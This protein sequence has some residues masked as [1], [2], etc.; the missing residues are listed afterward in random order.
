MSQTHKA[1]FQTLKDYYDEGNVPNLVLFGDY[2]SGKKKLLSDFVNYIYSK[3]KRKEEYI[4]RVNCLNANGI[5]FVRDDIKFFAQ[6]VFFNQDKNQFKSIIL[7]NAELL[8]IDAQSA[9]RRCIELFSKSTRFFLVV[10]NKA[11][12]LKP[13]LSRFSSFFVPR[14]GDTIRNKLEESK[15]YHKEFN[16]QDITKLMEQVKDDKQTQTLK[17]VK[18]RLEDAYYKGINGQNMVDYISNEIEDNLGKYELLN[19]LN[20]MSRFYRNER[21][22]MF[23]VYNLYNEFVRD[24]VK[25]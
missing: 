19:K 12:L 8:T 23:H 20:N 17:N 24:R 15:M 16:K 25:K 10:Q 2:Q 6:K 13:I 4:M 21:L 1:I 18:S 9:L 11:K 22:Y 5:K 3:T 14:L 7:Y